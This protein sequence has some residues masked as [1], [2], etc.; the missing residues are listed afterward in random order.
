MTNERKILIAMGAL[1]IAGMIAVACFSLGV[2][3]GTQGWTLQQPSLAG[4]QPPRQGQQQLPPGQ[5]QPG[6]PGQ[7]GQAQPNAPAGQQP[8][9]TLIGVVR[10][11]DEKGITIHAEGAMRPVTLTERTRY[12]ARTAEGQTVEAKLEDVEA[13]KGVAVYGTFSPDGHTL[14]ADAV[15]VL[16]PR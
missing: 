2:Y 10:H 13:G 12:A 9:P 4:P 6:Q 15:V 16:P 11:V 8:R 1:L 14:I 5:Q 3:V 7:P